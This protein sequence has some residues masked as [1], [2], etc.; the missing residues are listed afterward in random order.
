MLDSCHLKDLEFEGNNFI[1]CNGREGSHRIWE[2]LDRFVA[3]KEWQSQMQQW[4]V[5][6]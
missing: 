5:S 1:W 2:R 4:L 3:N 6:H